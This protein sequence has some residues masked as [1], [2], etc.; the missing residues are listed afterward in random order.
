[1]R[2]VTSLILTWR[3][4]ICLQILKIFTRL[5]VIDLFIFFKIRVGFVNN[6][7]NCNVLF[8]QN[9]SSVLL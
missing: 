4:Q 8:R 1:M 5:E 2:Y 6:H 3:F 9:D 7:P